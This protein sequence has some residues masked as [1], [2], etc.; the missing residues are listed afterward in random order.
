ME[1]SLKKL[2]FKY[3]ESTVLVNS[4]MEIRVQYDK[5]DWD[6]DC[7]AV[8]YNNG[9]HVHSNRI[10]G[11]KNWRGRQ[12]SVQYDGKGYALGYNKKMWKQ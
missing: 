7:F 2:E 5:Y 9:R 4:E 8:S 11:A 3:K 12:W 1:K 10:M 6:L